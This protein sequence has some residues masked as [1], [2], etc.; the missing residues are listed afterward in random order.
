MKLMERMYQLYMPDSE[1][2]S[3][4]MKCMLIGGALSGLALTLPSN[5]SALHRKLTEK[6]TDYRFDN[7]SKEVRMRLRFSTSC[8]RILGNALRLSGGNVQI[9]SSGG[10]LALFHPKS[11]SGETAKKTAP[12][13]SI[14]T[15]PA[16]DEILLGKPLFPGRSN[17]LS[18]L[19]IAM[20]KYVSREATVFHEVP[21]YLTFDSNGVLSHCEATQ[22]SRTDQL[23]TEERICRL[24]TSEGGGTLTY[25]PETQLCEAVTTLASF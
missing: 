14:K 10:L 5:I 24:R 8:R 21:V 4:L 1:S 9:M 22:Y 7:E 18:T 19:R 23:T 15:L 16:K 12:A 3:V 25:N 6:R 13:A 2:G 20:G 17:F 11:S